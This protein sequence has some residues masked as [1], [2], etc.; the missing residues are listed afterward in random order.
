MR[1]TS[2]PTGSRC[3]SRSCWAPERPGARRRAGHP[4]G[5]LPSTI[6]D[7]VLDRLSRRSPDAQ[8]VAR[9]G[10]VVGRCFIPDVLAEIMDVP[11]ASLDDPLQEL[12]EHGV[13]EPPGSRGLLD[14][15]HQLLRD[16]I[17]R[18]VPLRDRRRFHARAGE[19]GT[20]L[21]GQ[22]EIHSSRHFELAGDRRRAYDTARAGARQAA[23]IAAHREACELYRRAAANLPDDAPPMERV[24][25]YIALAREALDIED[26]QTAGD[27]SRQ[28]ATTARAA[29]ETVAAIQAETLDLE[30]GSRQGLA[31]SAEIARIDRLLAE[32]DALPPAETREA[33]VDLELWRALTR[34]RI[35]D[36]TGARDGFATVRRLGDELGDP[37]WAMVADWKGAVNEFAAGDLE[38]EH[39]ADRRDRPRGGAPRLWVHRRLGLPGRVAMASKVMDYQAARYWMS[40]GLRYADAIEQSFCAHVIRANTAL[41]DWATGTDWS[42][43]D[44]RG[45]QAIAD[46]GCLIGAA[47]AR[48]AVG[49]IALARGQTDLAE[50]ELTAALTF[51]EADEG[52]R[53]HPPAALGAGG[54][55]AD[56]R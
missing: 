31:A 19:F 9:A 33:R 6:E 41:V 11:P 24:E 17:Y 44:D 55:R 7:A 32:L 14:F 15:R 13:L 35:R 2:G 20:N 39:P 12:I 36:L 30:V 26:L 38:A 46:R 53:L 28:A 10:A 27:A 47:R 49:Y 54:G 25:V 22:S 3:T 4:R 52:D 43:A 21:E 29:G 48:W 40:E 18:S 45:R 42:A 37:E 23:R 16:A 8:A 5:D 51:G 1:S 50:E 34:T 56:R